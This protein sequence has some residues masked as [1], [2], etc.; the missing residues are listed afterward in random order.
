META[1]PLISA[2]VAGLVAWLITLRQGSSAHENWVRD[3]RH[4]AYEETIEA[5]VALRR[6]NEV[7]VD[8]AAES[9]RFTEALDG[10]R[11]IAPW[12]IRKLAERIE[13]D[14]S[15]GAVRG[16]GSERF[17]K[18]LRKLT[19]LLRDDLLPMNMR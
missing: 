14:V 1:M 16:D 8:I 4:A 19:S 5:S 3:K 15:A 9:R 6:A 10:L 2:L 18:D 12:T 11:L 13:D 17:E 7:G